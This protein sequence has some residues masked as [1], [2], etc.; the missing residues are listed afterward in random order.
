MRPPRRSRRCTLVRGARVAASRRGGGRIGCLEVERAVRPPVVVMAHVDAEDVLE[1]AATD[2]QQPVE[3]LSADAADPAL[4][5]RV[6]IR[7]PDRRADD[8]DTFAG[9]DG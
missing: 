5:V 9:E 8:P 1:L 7:R 2:D 3:T 4:D 6:R